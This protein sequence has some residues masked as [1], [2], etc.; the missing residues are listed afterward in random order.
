MKATVTF[1]REHLRAPLTLVMLVGIPA[2]F[3]LASA[4][5]LSEFANALGGGL[6]ADAASAFGA[7]WAA[8]FMAGAL[9]FFEASSARGADRRL[10]LA[11]FGVTRI[12]SCRIVS[13]VTMALVVSTIAFLALLISSGVAHPA[14][15]LAAVFAFALIYLAVG[16][17][18]GSIIHGQLEGSLTVI[19]VFLLDMFSGPGMTEK[20][21][22][23]SLSRKAADILIAAATGQSSP[24]GDWLK[25]VLVVTLAL[26]AAFCVFVISARS[27]L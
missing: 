10:A 26:S 17:L 19:F 15:A 8:A 4:N 16:V 12:A 24:A 23:L 14:H 3:V 2:L 9:G 1:T 11:G 7:G 5:V 20:A 27:R 13:A 6:A 22:P 25:L 18:V 21:S